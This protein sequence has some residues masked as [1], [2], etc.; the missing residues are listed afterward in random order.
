MEGLGL[1]FRATR[2]NQVLEELH[3]RVTL[4]PGRG[5]LVVGGA[6]AGDGSLTSAG[7]VRVPSVALL[8]GSETNYAWVFRVRPD[9]TRHHIRATVRYTATVG[10]ANTFDVSL[11]C[12]GEDKVLVVDSWSDWNE[13]ATL[14]GPGTAC[15]PMSAIATIDSDEVQSA[16]HAEVRFAIRRLAG[17]ANANTLHILAIELLLYKA[18]L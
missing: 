5:V 3:D 7:G 1:D 15:T 17:D 13:A 6:G 16:D 8:A 2:V 11:R 4:V 18:P 14:T 10:S 12:L 9:W